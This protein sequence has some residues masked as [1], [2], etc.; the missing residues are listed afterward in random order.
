MSSLNHLSIKSEHSS[1]IPNQ[2]TSNENELDA[3]QNQEAQERAS[4]LVPKAS[5]LH[6]TIVAFREGKH[7][8]FDFITLSIQFTDQ[9]MLKKTLNL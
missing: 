6:Q 8:L 4:L 2:K 5:S 9:K 7:V 3:Y 1:H